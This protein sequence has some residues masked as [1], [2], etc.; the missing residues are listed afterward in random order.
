[1]HPYRI[2]TISEYH[3]VTGLSKPEH[4]LISMIDIE[5][6]TPPDVEGP[7][8]LIF[9]FYSIAVK[10]DMGNRLKY[11]QQTC[12]FD[13]GILFCTAPGQVIN[14]QLKT[15]TEQAASGWM[16]LIHPDFLW[17]TP[18][19]KNIKQYGY[20]NYSVYE[21]LNLSD[22]EEVIVTNIAN[23]IKQ[24]YHNNIDKFSQPVI[25]AQL[26]VILTY[27]DR[28]Y[29]R[30]FLT[31]KIESHKII[32]RLEEVIS[33]YFG[34]EKLASNGLPTVA[35]IAAELNVSPSY[36]SEM[37]KALTG[38][39]T[40]QHIHDKLIEKAKEQLSTTGLSISEIAYGLGFEHLQSFSKLFK[41]KTN[42]S[43]LAFR[44]GFN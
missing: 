7:I 29:Q 27:I 5:T 44:K 13:E 38:Q 36:L 8:S 19:A 33:T 34:D 31:R 41:T 15:D 25:I 18:L 23:N 40:Q 32:E 42:L 20:F 4:P 1:M 37:L 39:S 21:A 28:F 9:D 11:G 16:I 10:R 2:K 35:Y 30:Q 17:N 6:V 43:P 12:G 24:E 22:K 14:I 26:E 3:R